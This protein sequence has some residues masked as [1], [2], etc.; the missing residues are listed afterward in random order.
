MPWYND[1]RPQT[2]SNKQNFGLTF[3]DLDNAGRIRIINQLLRLRRQLKS[4]ISPRQ[5]DN[6][7]LI[8]TW[9]LKEFGH[10]ENRT[11]DAYFCIAE[12]L[13]RFDLIAVQE[14]K[15]SLKDLQLVVKLLGT[16]WDYLV[17]DITGG[18]SGNNESFAYI[19]NSRRVKPTGLAGE[20]VL[21][22]EITAPLTKIKQLMRTPY[23]TGFKAGWKEFAIINVHLKPDNDAANQAIRKEEVQALVTVIEQRIKSKTIW[24]ENLLI[25]GDFNIYYDN[26]DILD[27]LSSKGFEQLEFLIDK[28]TNVTGSQ[29]YDKIFYRKNPYFDLSKP[30]GDLPGGVFNIFQEVFRLEEDWKLY[31]KDMRAHK[32]NPETLTTDKT[33]Q[34][35]YRNHWRVRQLSDHLPVWVAMKIDSSDD[36]LQ[37][38]LAENQG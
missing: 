37:E 31:K 38:K 15:R 17:T 35:Y 32:E 18:K 1:L 7:L 8:A 33:F 11:P 2:D 36:F 3:P 9:N 34:D 14:V 4:E 27:I 13:S 25:M 28:P 16:D 30:F 10:Y 26:Q 29:A 21:W 12:I 20:I 5:A 19:Y 23:I 6:N 22:E 24:N